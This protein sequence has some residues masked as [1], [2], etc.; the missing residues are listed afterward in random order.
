M[1]SF[2]HKISIFAFRVSREGQVMP[3]GLLGGK[4]TFVLLIE[5]DLDPSFFAFCME[6]YGVLTSD[7]FFNT[8]EKTQ[9]EK[10]SMFRPPS[11][12]S[13]A[14]FSKTSSMWYF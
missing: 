10:I 9:G 3:L 6:G 11:E 5:I 14:I 8:F 12:N 7:V 13:R 2:V 4:K 1:K